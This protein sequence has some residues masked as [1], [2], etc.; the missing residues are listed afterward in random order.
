MLGYNQENIVLDNVLTDEEI[1]QVYSHIAATPEERTE[2]V[3]VFS[4]KAYHGEVPENIIQSITRAAQSTTDIPIVLREISFARYQKYEDGLPVQLI[5]H[6]D[7]TFREHRLT[8]DLQLRSNRDW[9]IIVEGRP[10]TL[11]DNQALTFSGTSQVHWREKTEF[12]DGEFMDMIF[13]HFSARDY[14]PEEL[15]PPIDP[16]LPPTGKHDILMSDKKDYWEK[17]YQES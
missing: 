16:S 9:A 17:I 13:A 7:E 5:P 10:F 6:T 3:R 12:L 15:G 11:K 2:L 4:H 14:I 1:D 8:F